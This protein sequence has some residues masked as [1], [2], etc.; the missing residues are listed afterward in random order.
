M[1]TFTVT[2]EEDGDDI[3][4]PLPQEVM[5]Q[6]GIKEGDTLKWTDNND[7]SFT[8]TKQKTKLVLVDSIHTF[9]I[10]HVVEVPEDH[11]EYALDTVACD[12]DELIEV[13]QDFLG[14]QIASHRV[15]TEEEVVKMYREYYPFGDV[16]VQITDEEILK[17]SVTKEPNE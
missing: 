9:L 14:S 16:G 4:L 1:T 6:L 13:T 15:V 7:G 11:P 17:R 3:I 2:L 12:G 5:G 8:M 10:R